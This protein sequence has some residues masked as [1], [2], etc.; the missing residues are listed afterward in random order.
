[1]LPDTAVNISLVMVLALV[2]IIARYR[3]RYGRDGIFSVRTA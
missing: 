3:T 1:M 2:M